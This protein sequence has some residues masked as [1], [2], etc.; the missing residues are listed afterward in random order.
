M[1]ISNPVKVR[2]ALTTPYFGQKG[3]LQVT[4]VKKIKIFHQTEEY[5]FEHF[6]HLLQ[7]VIPPCTRPP[8]TPT[9]FFPE[10]GIH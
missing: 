10:Q 2:E 6:T 4:N 3:L 1:Y 9:I 8:P 7:S 5:F